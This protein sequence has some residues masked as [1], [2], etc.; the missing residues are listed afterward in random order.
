MCTECVRSWEL[1][2]E[3][4]T[5]FASRAKKLL[6]CNNQAYMKCDSDK[7]EHKSTM[8]RLQLAVCS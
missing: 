6:V 5:Y 2:K 1:I 3:K 8:E 7:I 4:D